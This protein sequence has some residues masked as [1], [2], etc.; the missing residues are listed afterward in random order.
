MLLFLTSILFFPS[1]MKKQITDQN[2][3]FS[4][5][6]SLRMSTFYIN[7]SKR[8]KEKSVWERTERYYVVLVFKRI[9]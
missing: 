9:F 8:M 3:I 2:E 5:R 4:Q 7:K 1:I 6:T